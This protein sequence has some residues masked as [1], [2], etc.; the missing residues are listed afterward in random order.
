MKRKGNKK[1]I[2]FLASQVEKDFYFLLTTF[3]DLYKNILDFLITVCA[4][5]FISF[6]INNVIS[7]PSLLKNTKPRMLCT[8]I[9]SL[10][11]RCY[12]N[13]C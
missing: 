3:F 6:R 4:V 1:I 11:V 12:S 7:L 9:E 13:I 8:L 10:Q 2:L 5:V